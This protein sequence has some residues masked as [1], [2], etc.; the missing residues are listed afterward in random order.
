M[1]TADGAATIW[2]LVLWMGLFHSRTIQR[3]LSF[4]QHLSKARPQTAAR[5]STWRGMHHSHTPLVAYIE[6][7]LPNPM[8]VPVTHMISDM[9]EASDRA[10]VGTLP[11]LIWKGSIMVTYLLFRIGSAKKKPPSWQMMKSESWDCKQKHSCNKTTKHSA[12]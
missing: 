10:A 2:E 6:T 9:R 1:I 12:I 4:T 8:S 7:F 3:V 11:Y 5:I